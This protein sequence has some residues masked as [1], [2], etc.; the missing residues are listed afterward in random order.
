MQKKYLVTPALPY[1]N[2]A[3][4]LGHL[5][6]HVM[7]NVFVRSLRMAKQDVLYVCGADSH[8]TPIEISA[9]KANKAPQELAKYWQIEQESSLKKFFIEFDGGYGSTHTEE[10]KHHAQDIYKA[11]KNNGHISQREIEQLFD[12]KLKRFLPD[13]MVKGTCPFCKAQEQYGDNC[14]ACGKTYS[15]TELINPK[16]VLSDETPVL[17]K[18]NHIFVNLENF[19]D[20]LSTWLNENKVINPE[21]YAYLQNWLKE[22]LKEWDISRDGPYF[23]FPI[24]G[25]ENKFFYVWLDAPIGYISLSEIAAKSLNKN[26]QDYWQDQNTEI[27][28]F[29]GKDIVYFHTLFWP[30][31]LMSANYTLPKKIFVHGMLTVNGEKMSKSRG[32]F[33]LADK[34]AQYINP[35]ALRYYFACKLST[36][37][38]DIDLNFDDFMSRV[39]SDLVNKSVNVISRALPL[40]HKFFAGK[41]CTSLDEN[42]DILIKETQNTVL[43]TKEYFLSCETAKAINAIIR[44][45]EQANKYLQD[46]QPWKLIDSDKN[47]A[48]QIITTGLYVGKVCFA[49]LKPVLPIS[50]KKL[51]LMLNDDQEFDFENILDDLSKKTLRS[52]EHL[53]SRIEE[54]AIKNLFT[55]TQEKETKIMNTNFINF[56][57][58]AKVEL[59]AAKIIDVKDVENSDKLLS[60]KLDVGELGEKHI[61]AGLKQ[62]LDLSDLVGKTLVIVANLEPRKMRFGVSE[63]MILAVGE[64]KPQ[65][66]F[67]SNAKPGDLIR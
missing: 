27:I 37:I 40:L 21:I 1:A 31:L 10:N 42:A 67:L 50:V 63:G 48:H 57:H 13:R 19:S 30:S 51:E 55:S 41:A 46:N 60:F 24:P 66:I 4:H 47:K 17:K 44:L 59:R 6:E 39:N 23:G 8:G 56:E 65:P 61:F 62:Y 7:V 43:L 33:I 15:P 9:Q 26:Y 11:L 2:G 28:H 34:F 29:I 22:G 5:L 35:E 18:S 54:S 36:N 25:E 16:S 45:S 64:E 32:T 3:L 49:L 38:E 53:F 58:F 20:K 12:P 52:Y 14:E